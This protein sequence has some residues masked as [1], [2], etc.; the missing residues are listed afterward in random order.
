MT[1]VPCD[2]MSQSHLITQAPLPLQCKPKL[3]VSLRSVLAPGH[4][5]SH[6]DAR[7]ALCFL[8]VHLHSMLM[9]QPAHPRPHRPD[10]AYAAKPHAFSPLLTRIVA[11]AT[12]DLFLQHLDET[13]T[14]YVRNSRNI[15]NLRL[16]HLQNTRKDLKTRV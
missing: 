16:K 8:C 11:C 13:S 14:T 1:R 6:R 9:L 7:V 4:P 12:P 3:H 15:C 5:C 2:H 10:I